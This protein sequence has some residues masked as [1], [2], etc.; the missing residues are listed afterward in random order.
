MLQY[1]S[2]FRIEIY[3]FVLFF[4]LYSFAGW[5]IEV[6][7]RSI[8]QKRFINAGFLFG[9]F[10]PVYGL[11]ACSI[12]ALS[13]VL[14]DESIYVQIFVYGTLP[15]VIEFFVGIL[16]EVLFGLK[17]WDYSENKF[18]L[19][20]RICL[21][22]S[23]GWA[24]LT[25]VMI[26]VVHPVVYR[27]VGIFDEKTMA[28]TSALIVI[29]FT[30]DFVF[31]MLHLKDFSRRISYLV[32][33]Y[34]SLTHAEIER[35]LG[36]FNRILEAFPDLNKQLNEEINTVLKRRVDIFFN[37][38]NLKINGIVQDRKP[39]EKEY[40]EIAKDILDN[41]N[42][43]KLQNYYHHDSSILDHVKKVSYL[44]YRIAKYLKLDYRSAIR[45]ALLHD[46]FLY[47]WRD[48]HEPE[49][50]KE[51]LHGFAHPK[52]ALKNSEENFSI[53]EIEKDIIIKHMWPLT[54]RPPRY[55]ESFVVTFADKYVSSREFI[56][57]YKKKIK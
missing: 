27:W 3:Q 50:A 35:I 11:A 32:S 37:T 49:L 44:S 28:I 34:F 6:I 53:N 47:D 17:L 57:K 2:L 33:D 30:V 4:T 48:H 54:L 41:P 1:L 8:A 56:N 36:S 9:T 55:R 42:F 29:Y 23:T 52:I 22:F 10:V 43:L 39:E 15:T 45:G 20:G 12:I 18:N 21:S 14:K 38:I 5:V 31:S 25:L 26:T 13:H 40:D 51:K 24:I 16:S 7:Y 19:M 46:F